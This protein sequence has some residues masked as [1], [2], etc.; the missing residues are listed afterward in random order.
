MDISHM[1]PRLLRCG[2]TPAQI[3]ELSDAAAKLPL[4]M[5]DGTLFSIPRLPGLT[6]DESE[7]LVARLVERLAL[8]LGQPVEDPGLYDDLG[9]PTLEQ[10]VKKAQQH[11]QPNRVRMHERV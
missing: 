7:L 5:E 9:C 11:E 4:G 8:E 2:L 6:L 10:L 1:E 3:K